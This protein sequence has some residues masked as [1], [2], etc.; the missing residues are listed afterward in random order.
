MHALLNRSALHPAL[1]TEC[2]SA[3]VVAD[4]DH[5][6]YPGIFGTGFFAKQGRQVF[7]FSALHCLQV[8]PGGAVPA[9]P[10][11]MIPYRHTGSTSS[12][13]DFV[14]I[15]TAFTIGGD[16]PA[17]RLDLVACPVLPSSRLRDF[18]HLLARSVKLPQSGA[19]LDEYIASQQ[20]HAAIAAGS[21]AGYVIG[22]PRASPRNAITYGDAGSDSVISTEAVVIQGKVAFSGLSGHLALRLESVS[23]GLSGFS[24]S[25]VFAPISVQAKRCFSL[26]GMAV[27]GSTQALNLIPV[28]RLLDAINSD[29]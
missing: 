16:D 18:K 4:L 14:R 11:L 27:C 23:C 5:I 13:D 2:V 9:F 15:E 21:Y 24:G 26:I 1:P 20:G 25:P 17:D 19:W 6:Q 3:N 22:H 12:P 7:Y 29:A 28:G 10:T 8:N